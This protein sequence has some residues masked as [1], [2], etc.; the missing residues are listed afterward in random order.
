MIKFQWVC[1]LGVLCI[2]TTPAQA[3]TIEDYSIRVRK[4]IA[5]S[6]QK[7]RINT[8][9][10][11][12]KLAQSQKTQAQEGCN[13]L[14]LKTYANTIDADV[15]AFD[16]YRGPMSAISIVSNEAHV[17]N[18]DLLK[19]RNVVMNG[20]YEG[21]AFSA[22]YYVRSD[23]PVQGLL[24]HIQSFVFGRMISKFHFVFEFTGKDLS[25]LG[26]YSFQKNSNTWS[27]PPQVSEFQCGHRLK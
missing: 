9:G 17:V 23:E 13:I 14:S 8:A 5:A 12:A 19:M 16:G 27:I 1:F 18:S 24:E 22:T 6:A 11:M 4:N 7:I 3:E 2:F 20:L 15:N 26:Y 10:L 21:N 25:Y